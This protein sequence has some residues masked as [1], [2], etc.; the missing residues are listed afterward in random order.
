M[1]FTWL[2]TCCGFILIFIDLDGFYE[3]THAIVGIITFVL[4]FLQPI[5]GAI[6][7]HHKAKKLFRLWHVLSGNVTYVLASK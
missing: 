3:H 1:F 5:F 4:C 6:N 2:L 7:P